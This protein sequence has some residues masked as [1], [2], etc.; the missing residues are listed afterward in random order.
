MARLKALITIPNLGKGG[1]Q[2]VFHQQLDYL[3]T[4][5]DVTGCVFNWDGAFASDK[6][7][8]IISLNVP[9]GGSIFSKIYYFWRRCVELRRIK[10]KYGIQ[11]SI[12]HLEGADYVNILS[13]VSERTVCCVHGTKKFDNNIEGIIG[14]LRH[15]FLIPTLYK[16]S[17][18][19]TVS[20]GIRS[21][22]I[23]EYKISP[24]R[25]RCIPNGFDVE[26]IRRLAREP[27]DSKI[28]NLWPADAMTI[29]SHCRLARQKNLPGMLNV[30][31]AARNNIAVRLFILGD[32]EL[33]DD[34]FEHARQLGL[35]T[36]AF[37]KQQELSGEFDVYFLGHFDNPY[38][39]VAASDLYIM[40]SSWEGFPLALCEA[41]ACGIP[42]M[43]ADCFT[44]P[45]EVI[46]PSL[47]TPQ[48]V[49]VPIISDHGV[50]MP[51]ADTNKQILTW[52]G[53]IKQ[54]LNDTSARKK[55]SMSGPERVTDFDIARVQQEWLSLLR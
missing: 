43:A 13:R 1:A 29:V 15:H 11:L 19:V 52:S 51:L 45:R 21:E 8:N 2:R 31:A 55:F 6:K 54:I 18:I 47:N 24:E 42:V 10:K 53:M 25:V 37:W 28:K 20:D 36:F 5:A 30:I 41:M 27:I 23:R 46:A 33:R 50:L 7:K 14:W 39:I 40:T 48:P 9:A 34:L 4:V 35:K 32:G 44:G 3:S 49:D 12:S 17:A 26:T 16:K 22:L 38:Q